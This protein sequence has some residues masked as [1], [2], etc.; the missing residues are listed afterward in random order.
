LVALLFVSIS[1]E[2][3]AWPAPAF[4]RPSRFEG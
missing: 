2:A 4:I 3:S 1:L